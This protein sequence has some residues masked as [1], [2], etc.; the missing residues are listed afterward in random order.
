M[1]DRSEVKGRRTKESSLVIIEVTRIPRKTTVLNDVLL[2]K[3]V[4]LPKESPCSM[5]LR[6]SNLLSENVIAKV[7]F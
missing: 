1:I 5:P 3:Y 6:E 7:S 4:G 2:R